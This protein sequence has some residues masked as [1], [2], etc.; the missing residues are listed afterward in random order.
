MS[1]VQMPDIYLCLSSLQMTLDY[2][3]ALLRYF[4][5][6]KLESGIIKNITAFN[7]F[8][9]SVKYILS[10]ADPE[11]GGHWDRT[12]LEIRKSIRFY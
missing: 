9:L 3:Q 8:L 6:L 7:H 11:G 10:C 12:P 2:N 1:A 4:R 5:S